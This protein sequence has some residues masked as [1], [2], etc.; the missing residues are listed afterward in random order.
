[1]SLPFRS[2]RRRAPFRR[3]APVKKTAIVIAKQNRRRLN[4]SHEDKYVES[5]L[6]FF[7]SSA[8]GTVF[9]LSNVVVGNTEVQRIGDKIHALRL[10]LMLRVTV[11]QTP[12]GIRIIIFK[13]KQQ[14]GVQPVTADVLQM[15][16]AMSMF[17][18]VNLER[19]KIMR[20]VYV[21]TT[22]NQSVN[23]LMIYRFDVKLNHNIH[24]I[25]AT[26]SATGAGSGSVYMLVLTEVASGAN[27]TSFVA[28]LT[29]SD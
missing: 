17:N 21:P 13:D 10:Q 3:R 1:M 8:T 6:A 2:I 7:T 24:Y 12:D 15:T 28:R 18:R 22:I 26:A 16:E 23:S 19:F 20:D 25:N 9:P 14:H 11:P 27:E 4:Q 29:F 5:P